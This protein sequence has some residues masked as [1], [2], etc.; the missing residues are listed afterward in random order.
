[1]LS[2]GDASTKRCNTVAGAGTREVAYTYA[3][4]SAGVAYAVTQACSRGQLVGC[5][6]DR[7]K[8]DDNAI[9]ARPTL[10]GHPRGG[11]V[12]RPA[13]GPS[14]AARLFRWGGCSADVRYGLR[15]SRVFLDARE[16]G[17]EDSRALV[18]LHNNRVGRKV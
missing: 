4:R 6:C 1:L 18:N 14:A 7:S 13:R 12:P 16:L 10:S 5:G 15:F 11:V 2:Y 8:T 17:N 3:V 9:A